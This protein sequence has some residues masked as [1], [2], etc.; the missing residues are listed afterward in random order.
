MVDAARPEMAR[1]FS[2]FGAVAGRRIREDGIVH[3]WPAGDDR[4]WVWARWYVV[5]FLTGLS[6]D[7]LRGSGLGNQSQIGLAFLAEALELVERP[8]VGTFEAGFLTADQGHGV[9][10]GVGYQAQAAGVVEFCFVR[11]V[12]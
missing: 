12:G 11:V 4:R 9:A 7:W 6:V 1:D 2:Y 8:V 10:V 3:G 5:G